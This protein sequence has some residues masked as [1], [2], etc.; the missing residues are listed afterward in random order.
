MRDWGLRWLEVASVRQDR[1]NILLDMFQKPAIVGRWLLVSAETIEAVVVLIQQDLT[2]AALLI[3]TLL[4]AYNAVSLTIVH[5][6]PLRRLP[7]YLV[8]IVDLIGVAFAAS[9]TGGAKSPFINECFLIIFAASLFYG[10]PGG[11]LAGAASSIIS[12]GAAYHQ[13]V[14]VAYDIQVLIPYFLISGAFCGYLVERLTESVDKFELSREHAQE[15]A[16]HASALR[17]EMELARTMQEAMLPAAPA[18]HTGVLVGSCW[19]FAQ[20]VGGDFHFFLTENHRLALVLGDVSGNGVPAAL[21]ATSIGLLLPR[22][23]PLD[24]PAKALAELNDDLLARLPPDSFVTM[25][26]VEIEAD[27]GELHVWNAGHPPLLIWDT[28]QCDVVVPNHFNPLLGVIEDWTGTPYLR[29]L[30]AGDIL[31]VYSDGLIEVRNADGEMFGVERAGA[32]LKE[33]AAK[34]P[35]A[36]AD[37]MLETVRGWGIVKDDL[38]VVV[39]TYT[40]ISAA[41]LAAPIHASLLGKT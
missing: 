21:A 40:G 10:I 27:T 2:N 30:E 12:S 32:V 9:V 22:L 4:C 24:D 16:M 34:P 6:V 18:Q 25:I 20:E 5:I 38:T 39:A 29:H 33:N 31:V 15:M 17:R 14:T 26:L 13:S 28:S 41:P 11:L 23:H 19:E 36:I 8:V 35:Q 7:V 3:L 37:A 1:T